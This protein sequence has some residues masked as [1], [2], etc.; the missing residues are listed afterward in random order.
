MSGFTEIDVP[1]TLRI[2]A[3]ATTAPDTPDEDA[4]RPLS[5]RELD[6]AAIAERRKEAIERELSF[7]VTME[8][9]ARAAGGGE[10]L[11]RDEPQRPIEDTS[12]I[13]SHAAPSPSPTA[14][15]P[16]STTDQTYEPRRHTINVGGQ[17]FHVTDAELQHLASVGAVATVAMQQQQHAQPQPPTPPRHVE[18]APTPASHETMEPARVDRTKLAETWRKMSFGTEED[19]VAALQELI[20][21]VAAPRAPDPSQIAQQ[22]HHQLRQEQQLEQ[23]LVRVGRDYQDVFGPMDRT[24]TPEEASVFTMRGQA[25]ALALDSIRRRDAM[26]GVQRADE[27]AYREAAD[28]VRRSLLPGQQPQEAARQQSPAQ[29]APPSVAPQGERIE[30]KR[31]APRQ[32]SA[33]GRTAGSGGETQQSRA[34][35]PSE[36]VAWMAQR[37]NQ[38]SPVRTT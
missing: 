5:K 32:P 6:M 25:A 8:D 3:E 7:G 23:T 36:V 35:T 1:E 12:D 10:P 27:A 11:D 26:M 31:A 33:V 24:W 37:R 18:V 16:T 17:V 19:G 2:E 28:M 21:T 22:V 14:P 34:P 13:P 29:A 4:P 9:E 38:Q 20:S 30:R 15:T